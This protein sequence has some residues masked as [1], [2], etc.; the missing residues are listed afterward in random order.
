MGFRGPGMSEDCLYL[1]VWTPANSANEK[2]PVL[3]YFFG[4]GLQAGDG[5]EPRYDGESMALKGIVSVTVNYRLTVFGFMAHPE[6]T[7]EAPYH[8]SGNYGFLDQNAALKWVQT[9][10]AAFGGDP[11][12]VTI[13]GQSAGSRSTSIQLVSPLS[14]NLIAGA[15]ME[16]GS[17]VGANDPPTL[18][19]AEKQGLHFMNAAGASSLKD[20]RAMPADKLLELTAQPVNSGFGPVADNYLLPT[21][22]LVDYIAAGKAAH[23]PILEGANSQEQ[24][25][26]TVLGDN[27]PTAE[28]FAATVKKL[29]GPDA[30]RV[31]A[32]YPNIQ[33]KEQVMNTAMTMGSEY[34]MGYN[35]WLFGEGFRKGSGKPVYRYLYLRPRKRFLGATNQV[36][37]QAGGIVTDA[38]AAAKRPPDLGAAHSA[39]I[40]YALG[41][42]ATNIRFAWEPADYKLSQ[43]MED[44]FANFIKTGDPNGS[45]LPKWP[46]YS[47]SDNFQIM[48]FDV[49]STVGPDAG[50]PHYVVF[51]QIVHK[52]RTGQGSDDSS[53]AP[54]SATG[55]TA[56]K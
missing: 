31:L 56:A 42:L 7:A 9:N 16:S 33:T 12:R 37:G 4:G 11:S 35:M 36:P 14:K 29:Y 20:L 18:A 39:E 34:P 46:A 45:A 48:H 41:N 51:D 27:P 55:E 40:E 43:L 17:V 26:Q 38:A 50:R 5:S 21:G 2:L 49:E 44:Y 1:N 13:A 32:L 47:P 8:A 23:V 25:Y 52:K 19:D 22:S 54:G 3:V 15:I 6:L 24:S 30:D 10:I 28:G 53:S